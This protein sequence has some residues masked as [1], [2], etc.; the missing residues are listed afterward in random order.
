MPTSN[1]QS[2]LTLRQRQ[3]V[4]THAYSRKEEENIISTVFTFSF[5][6]TSV[7]RNSDAIQADV[8]LLKGEVMTRLKSDIKT[9]TN[10]EQHQ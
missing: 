2:A 8:V 5:T 10:Y 4:S 7:F 9:A 6:S 1:Q 3:N